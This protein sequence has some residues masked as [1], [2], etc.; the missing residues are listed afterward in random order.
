MI[1]VYYKELKNFL[2][3]LTG[4]IAIIIFLVVC[5]LFVWVIT[6]NN[7][8]NYNYASIAQLFDIAPL[9]F[10]ILIPGITMNA[11]AEEKQN[12][13]IEFLTTKP[14]SDFQII[15]GKYLAAMTIV[16]LAILPTLIYYYSVYQLG[17][18]KGNIDTGAVIGSY[19]G[20]FLLAG[21]FAAIGMFMS[22][23]TSNQ[24]AAF[25]L[26]AFACFFFYWIFDF[27]SELPAFY[28]KVDDIIKGIGIDYHYTNIS[29]GRIDT[30]DV[31]YFLSMILFFLWLTYVTLDKRKW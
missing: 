19:V 21:I 6:E 26:T 25:I 1:S 2:S 31:V 3:S 22:I 17:S 4:Y 9:V 30:R 7:L 29:R 14:L 18:P 10:I 12:G 15:S 8:F 27:I 28:G 5:S 24:I 23:L 13:T 16:F 11:F 20:L